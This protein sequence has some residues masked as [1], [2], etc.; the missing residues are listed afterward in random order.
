MEDKFDISKCIGGRIKIKTKYYIHQSH[1][2]A[3]K[4]NKWGIRTERATKGSVYLPL[5]MFCGKH[6]NY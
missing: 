6:F 3:K 4:I 1:S 2:F 5:S